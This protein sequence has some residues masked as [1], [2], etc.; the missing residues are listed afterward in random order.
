MVEVRVLGD[1]QVLSHGAPVDLPQSRKTRALLAYLAVTGKRHQR[2]RLCELFWELP[3]DPRAAL[4]WSLSK[5]RQVF[6]DCDVTFETD[7][8]SVTLKLG[9]RIDC[10]ELLALPRN[11]L[12]SVEASHLERVASRCNGAFLDDLS[13]DRCPDYEAWRRSVA[14][15]VEIAQVRLYRELIA[16]FSGEPERALTFAVRLRE[17]LPDSAEIAAEIEALSRTVR[18]AAARPAAPPR[19]PTAAVAA[20]AHP[21]AAAPQSSAA[22]FGRDR[23]TRFCKAPDGTRLAYAIAGEGPPIVRAAHWLSHLGFDRESPIWRHWISE[24]SRNNTLVRYDERCNGLS[25]WNVADLSFDA[26][27]S[28][29]ETV[30]DAAGL[31]RFTL[32]GISQSCALSVAYAVRHPERVSG[33]ILYGGYVK[34][35]RARGDAREIATREAMNTL[36]REGWGQDNPLFRQLFSSMF[37]RHASPEQVAWL[38]ELQF[39]TVSPHNAWRLSNAFAEMDVME[40]LP[41]VRAPTL[42]LHAREDAV[43]PLAAGKAFAY[44]IPD[45]RFIELDSANHILLEGEPAFGEFLG[46]V[47]AFIA[48]TADRPDLRSRQRH[49]PSAEPAPA[50]AAPAP[51][52]RKPAASVTRQARL[53]ATRRTEG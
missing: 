15:E 51:Y 29:L 35:W 16:R 7:R 8:A 36:I 53:N 1:F 41:Q 39:R 40:L 20:S 24:L 52:R 19:A 33:L 31:D 32:I 25:D 17:V 50:R 10:A 30:V 28:D 11:D 6:G 2:E 5:I 44:D 37:I 21:P 22:Q 14:Q 9:S 49:E 4:R 38:D 42:V 3:D 23:E 12:S 27:V 45:A 18:E 13:L 43:A 46:H 34:G 26:M 48:A 47:S